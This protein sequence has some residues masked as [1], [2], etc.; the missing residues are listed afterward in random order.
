LYAKL[1]RDEW[2]R[3]GGYP[4]RLVEINHRTERVDNGHVDAFRLL[5]AEITELKCSHLSMTRFE[6]DLLTLLPTRFVVGS[7]ARSRRP[8]CFRL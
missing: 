8:W 4:G 1:P 2:L 7:S 3:L 6:E 5:T